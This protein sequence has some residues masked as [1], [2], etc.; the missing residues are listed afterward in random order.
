MERDFWHSP[1]ADAVFLHRKLGGLYLL[2]AR[3]KARVDVNKL[4]Q[5][6]L[7]TLPVT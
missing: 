3:L 2:A 7:A 1:P 6:H 4:V 5:G